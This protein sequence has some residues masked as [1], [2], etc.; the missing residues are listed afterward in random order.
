MVYLDGSWEIS[1]KVP[2]QYEGDFVEILDRYSIGY[3]DG[4]C[5]GGDRFFLELKSGTPATRMFWEEI[6]KSEIPMY[7]FSPNLKNTIEPNTVG[8]VFAK[9]T[10][11][12]KIFKGR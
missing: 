7:I 2:M 1:V 10:V 4:G 5:F 11:D 6:S 8:T 3:V 9:R 12:P